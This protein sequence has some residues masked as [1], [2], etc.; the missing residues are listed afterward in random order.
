M[1]GATWPVKPGLSEADRDRIVELREGNRRQGARAIAQALGVR[2]STVQFHLYAQGMAGRRVYRE[3]PY[4]RAGKWVYPFTPAEDAYLAVA[5]A[6]LE[7]GTA[8]RLVRLSELLE[9]ACGRRRG[10]H[11]IKMRLIILANDEDGDDA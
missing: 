11:S 4:L 8:K 1:T 2:P 7:P 3:K 9:R 6:E 5:A 10:V